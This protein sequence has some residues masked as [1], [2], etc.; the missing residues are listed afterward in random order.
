MPLGSLGGGISYSTYFYSFNLLLLSETSRKTKPGSDG[1][2]V[3]TCSNQFRAARATFGHDSH[4]KNHTLLWF[5]GPRGPE[6]SKVALT[7]FFFDVY[8]TLL[9]LP[10]EA[11]LSSQTAERGRH[12]PEAPVFS[13][14]SESPNWPCCWRPSRSSMGNVRA[15]HDEIMKET[16]QVW[17]AKTWQIWCDMIWDDLVWYDKH[18]G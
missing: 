7:N 3:P 15:Y 9:V 6:A 18:D 14:S 10:P 1:D 4:D 8:M 13:Q 11:Y 5:W 17:C 2:P 16:W 12:Y